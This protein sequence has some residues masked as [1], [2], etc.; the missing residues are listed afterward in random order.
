VLD[1]VSIKCLQI[2]IGPC[3]RIGKLF[4]E[5][6]IPVFLF[7]SQYFQ[8]LDDLGIFS[9]PNIALCHLFFLILHSS[10]FVNIVTVEQSFQRH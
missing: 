1:D 10:S 7:C 8:Q 2:L 3:K 5:T 6:D 4:N 9:G